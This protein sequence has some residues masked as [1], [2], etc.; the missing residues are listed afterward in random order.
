MSAL[1]FLASYPRSGNTFLRVLLANYLN[2]RPGPVRLADLPWLAKGEH[3]ETLWREIT[4]APPQMRTLEQEWG[5]RETY[6]GRL[7]ATSASTPVFVKTHTVNAAIS[8]VPAFDLNPYDRAIYVLRHPCD[9]AV[10]W[11]DFYGKSIDT[12][13]ADLLT[14]GRYI[15]GLPDHG[16]ELTGSWGQHV[17]SWV[18]AAPCPPLVLRYQDLCVQPAHELARAVAFLGLKLE[19]ERI[20][21]AAVFSRFDRL[22]Q[23]EAQH[24]FAEASPHATSQRFFREGRS[25]QWSQAMSSAQASRLYDAYGS[26][27]ERYRLDEAVSEEMQKIAAR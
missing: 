26:L 4:G 12:A 15:Q 7:R 18:D 23:D 6:F 11:A 22:R 19:P 5:A 21:R 20:A 24:G 13:I 10:S 17:S 2:D 1:F 16:F 25:G 27:I 8:G 14:P 9:V 3:V